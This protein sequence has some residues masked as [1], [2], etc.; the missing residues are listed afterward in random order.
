MT[1][2]VVIG[3][4]NI[5][6]KDDGIGIHLI[7]ILKN[8]KLRETIT[9]VDGGTAT[10]DMLAYLTDFNKVILI[11]CLRGGYKPGTIY[12]IKP[13]EIKSCNKENL[14]LHDVQILEVIKMAELFGKKPDVIIYGIEPEDIS[15]GTEITQ[16][17]INKISEFINYLKKEINS[18]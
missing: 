9:L 5:L 6:F 15:L 3:I 2:K 14:S 10:I 1:K 11:D 18:F 4:G 8:E 12:K 16:V 13:E 7:N 17:L